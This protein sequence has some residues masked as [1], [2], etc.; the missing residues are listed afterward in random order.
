MV[1]LVDP[2]VNATET[3]RLED[4][5]EDTCPVTLKVVPDGAIAGKQEEAELLTAITVPVSAFPFWVNVTV[6][7]VLPDGAAGAKTTLQFP[8]TTGI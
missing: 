1:P 3:F 6:S 4:W 7:P 5:A 2:E 8:V